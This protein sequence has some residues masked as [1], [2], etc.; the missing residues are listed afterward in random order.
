LQQLVALLTEEAAPAG[1]TGQKT[2][3]PAKK[4]FW[5]RLFGG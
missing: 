2:A 1:E 4:S 3:V 5:Q